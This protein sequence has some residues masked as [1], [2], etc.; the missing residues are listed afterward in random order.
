MKINVFKKI[1]RISQIGILKTVK[2]FIIV[3]KE[4]FNDL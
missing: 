4:I 3:S 1:Y 2:V